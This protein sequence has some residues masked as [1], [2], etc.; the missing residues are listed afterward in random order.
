MV[1]HLLSLHFGERMEI[2]QPVPIG[3]PSKNHKFDLVPSDSCYIGDVKNYSWSKSGNNPS[4]KMACINEAIFYLSF[5]PSEVV[6]F[7]VMRKDAH[8]NRKE[9][10]A[11]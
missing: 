1:A 10:L 6:R 3:D 4:A 9:S 11:G 7:V 5:L 8:P 2:D